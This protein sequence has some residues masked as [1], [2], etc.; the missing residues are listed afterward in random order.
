MAAFLGS[1]AQ[2]E[3][4]W[5]Q[6]SV[7]TAAPVVFAASMEPCATAIAEG[8]CMAGSAYRCSGVQLPGY[9][10][11]EYLHPGLSHYTRITGR[12]LP[13]PD[14]AHTEHFQCE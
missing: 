5:T 11:T 3:A 1:A 6:S 12:V 13:P 9:V 7:Y 2:Q 10:L 8:C 4:S 14:T